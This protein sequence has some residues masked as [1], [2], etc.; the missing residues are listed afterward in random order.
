MEASARRVAHGV[1]RASSTTTRASSSTSAPP[2]P[3]R[4]SALLHIGSRPARR[5][6]GARRREPARDPVAVR[7]DADAPAAAVV[8]RRRRSARRRD[9]ARRGDDCCS[10]MYARVAVLPLD[11][12]SDRDGARESRRADRRRVRPPA[13]AAPICSALGDDLRARLARAPPPCSRSPAT[14]SR[15]ERQPGAA[16]IDR[17][18]QSVRRPDQPGAGRTAARARAAPTADELA[19]AFAR[20][21]QRH[22]GRDAKHGL[23]PCCRTSSRPTRCCRQSAA[24]DTQGLLW[25]LLYWRCSVV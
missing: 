4:S 18:S 6:G 12:R 14:A 10:A 20:D 15:L 8:A 3:S 25:H 7:L 19:D 21:R 17:R 23:T 1:S 9:R 11:A 13:R 2:R 22:R 24:L 5:G 16:A